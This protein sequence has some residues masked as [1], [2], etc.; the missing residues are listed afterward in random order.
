MQQ[1]QHTHTTPSP[2]APPLLVKGGEGLVPPLL[3]KEG[4][5]AQHDGVVSRPN[6][7]TNLIIRSAHASL[8]GWMSLISTSLDPAQSHTRLPAW[9]CNGHLLGRLMMRDGSE[10]NEDRTAHRHHPVACGAT[11][12][13]ERRGELIPPLLFKEGW[14][15]QHDGVVSRP[16]FGTDLIIRPAHHEAPQEVS[17]IVP[18]GS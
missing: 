15:A 5:H 1:S 17:D 12:P 14:H 7:G 4:W 13:R 18:G 6:F 8:P 10:M 9:H 16:N 3:F 11:P 2:A